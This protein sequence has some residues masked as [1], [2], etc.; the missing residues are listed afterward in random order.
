MKHPEFI[1]KLPF[2]LLLVFVFSLFFYQPV[3]A[4]ENQQGGQTVVVSQGEIVNEDYFV[5]APSI[6]IQGTIIGDAYLAAGEVVVSG[7]V[8]GDLLVAGGTVTI[9]GR[10]AQDV[11]VIGGQVTISGEVGRNITATG[12]NVTIADNAKAGGSLAA[13]GVNVTVLTPITQGV[14]IIGGRV[15]IANHIGGNANITAGELTLTSN[16]SIAG[17]LTRNPLQLPSFQTPSPNV[18]EQKIARIITRATLTLL[19]IDLI[20]SFII[21]LILIFIFPVIT[22]TIVDTIK[23]RPLGILGTGL[24]ILILVPLFVFILFLAI[25]GIPLGFVLGEIFLI[26]LYFAKIYVSLLI[27][28]FILRSVSWAWG[29]LLGLII[30]EILTAVPFVG[31][32][33]VLFTMLFGLGAIFLGLKNVYQTL[34]SKNQI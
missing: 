10:V 11:R 22:R 4:Q 7:V 3:L 28:T 31:P 13:A 17:T 30:Y 33:V 34:R 21:G 27:G 20:S 2:G 12:G 1:K 5:A 16:A 19:I 6:V 32:L 25:V 14:N 15:L 29:L 8:E 26:S 23:A 18:S 9:T 24:L